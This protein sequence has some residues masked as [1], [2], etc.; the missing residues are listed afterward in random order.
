MITKYVSLFSLLFTVGLITAECGDCFAGK[1]LEELKAMRDLYMEDI[2]ET[3]EYKKTKIAQSEHS[4]YQAIL[5]KVKFNC[6]V[7]K[8]RPYAASL[9]GASQ[10]DCDLIKPYEEEYMRL[11]K[12]KRYAEERLAEVMQPE[13]KLLSKCIVVKEYD[14][15]NISEKVV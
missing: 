3:L 13:F 9:A 10:Q 1:S 2:K 15:I 7:Y 14:A 5:G 4:D 12:I 8:E 11:E 6:T